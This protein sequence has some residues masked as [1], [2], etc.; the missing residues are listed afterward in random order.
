LGL[1]LNLNVRCNADKKEALGRM[2]TSLKLLALGTLSSFAV[3]M[4]AQ[5]QTEVFTP[6]GESVPSISQTDASQQVEQLPTALEPLE[7]GQPQADEFFAP[8]QSPL[9]ARTQ[10]GTFA[11]PERL[12]GPPPGTQTPGQ[13]TPQRRLNLPID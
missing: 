12:I 3:S 6:S 11:S 1:S 10:T 8:S 7:V 4:P 5:G 2:N 13:L 9:P